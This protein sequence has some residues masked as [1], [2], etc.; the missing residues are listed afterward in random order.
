MNFEIG[1]SNKDKGT[2]IHK[3]TLINNLLKNNKQ[4][5]PSIGLVATT[6]SS[7]ADRQLSLAVI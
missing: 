3:D 2:L 5:Q 6:G 1:R 4:E 7:N